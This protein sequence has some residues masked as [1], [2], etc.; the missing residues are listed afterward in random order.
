VLY[1]QRGSKGGSDPDSVKKAQFPK[2]SF[3]SFKFQSPVFI[4]FVTLGPGQGKKKTITD[5]SIV[6]AGNLESGK[7]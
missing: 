7:Q 6:V 3:L 1:L 2:Y 5:S 4:R